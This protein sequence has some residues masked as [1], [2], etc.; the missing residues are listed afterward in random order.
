MQDTTDL[1]STF[2][3][4]VVLMLENRSFDNL[5]GYLYTD[6]LPK[7]KTF[8]GLY[9]KTI[10]M[11]VPPEAKGYNEHPFIEP[12]KKGDYHQPFPDPGEVY[13]HV[14]TQL[15]NYINTAR[16]D[17]RNIP[18]CI[19]KAPYNIPNPLPPKEDM[20]QGFVK[21]YINTLNALPGK[22]GRAFNNPDYDKYSIIMNCF[23]P[24]KVNV[25]ST[26]A[27]DFA[28]FDHWF[29]S[30]PSQ[31]WCNR[32]FWHAATSGGQLVNPLG[33]CGVE[34]IWDAMKAWTEQ[35]WTNTTI[36]ERMEQ[37]GVS[38][39]VFTEDLF[40]LTT[41][42]NGPFKQEHHKGSLNHFKR[43][44][45]K[46]NKLPQYSFLEPKFMGQHNDQHPSSVDRSV[47][48][49]QTHIGSVLLGEHLIWEIYTAIF[50][51]P[52]SKYRDN[53]L[54]I[55]TYDEHGG[56]F[57]H[58]TPGPTIPPKKGDIGEMG[59]EFDRLGVRVPMV[60]VSANIQKNTIVNEVFEH[61]SFIKTMCKKWGM[62][63]LTDRDAAAKSFEQVFSG[64]KRT[65]FPAIQE[66]NIP[67]I[68]PKSYNDDPLNDLQRSIL[69]GAN[70]MAKNNPMAMKSAINFD[71]A[72]Q[73]T[74]VGEAMDHLQK[75]K[76]FIE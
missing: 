63:H 32:A 11:P 40:S 74:T 57:D 71:T 53:T 14:N 48:D 51:D 56:C 43:L 36:F 26:L 24:E 10:K 67:S 6:D 8:E 23:S 52:I 45:K 20:M 60:M 19:M 39:A 31:T 28:I 30:V 29:C 33:E 5:L 1:L 46:E 15:Y 2:D 38:H 21:D 70:F 34:N 58:V 55:I 18:A 65:D 7:G 44:L 59:F 66:P 27:K 54:L 64:S 37:N 76:D 75:I 41:L 62:P 13:Q 3:H 50:I 49:N 68:D 25:L 17:N 47:S 22:K 4:V 12:M 35:V 69:I 16:P 9:G 72:N 61:T 73:I 42:V